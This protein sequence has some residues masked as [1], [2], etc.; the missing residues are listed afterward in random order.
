MATEGNW[1]NVLESRGNDPVW[2][3][4]AFIKLLPRHKGKYLSTLMSQLLFQS[5]A[6]N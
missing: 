1:E 6:E 5:Y 3:L 2:K 4:I